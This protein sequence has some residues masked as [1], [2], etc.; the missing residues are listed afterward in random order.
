[1]PAAGTD[2]D[3]TTRLAEEAV[4]QMRAHGVPGYPRSYEIW[5]TH[6]SG[7]NAALSR[8]L[9]EALA[10]TGTLEEAQI[11]QLWEQHLSPN[12]FS[13]QAERTSVSVIGE[14]ET[15]MEMMD[16]ALGSSARYGESLVAISA[17]LT[18]TVD[19][20]RIREIVASLVLATREAVANNKTLENRLKESKS[21]IESLRENLEAMRSESLTDSLTGLPNRRYLDSSLL[22]SVDQAAVTGEPLALLMIDVDHFKAFNDTW[23]H[24][25]GD[26]VLRLVSMSMKSCVRPTDTPARFGGEEFA[27]V[28]PQ[29]NLQHALLVGERIR[30]AVMGRELVK[31]STGESL[32]RVTVSVGAAVFR[33]GDTAPILLERA[34]RCLSEAKRTGRNKTVAETDMRSEDLPQVA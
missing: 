18:E 30:Q 14:I 5:Y 29:T 15:V 1:M 32:G 12:R 9:T 16:L 7:Q 26:Q 4:A 20:Q 8:A 33:R 11:D 17:D 28:L 21:E 23:G 27:I 10:K 13:N 31:R 3:Y 24:L 22:Q 6:L 2:R 25:T 34:D 19:R